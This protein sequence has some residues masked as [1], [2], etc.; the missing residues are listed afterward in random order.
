[1]DE[2]QTV[3]SYDVVVLGT[4]ATVCRAALAATDAGA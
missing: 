1:M 3:M 4:G 2:T